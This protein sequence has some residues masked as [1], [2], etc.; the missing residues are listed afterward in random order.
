MSAHDAQ[1]PVSGDMQ[2]RLLALMQL[3]A[4]HGVV[5]LPRYCANAVYLD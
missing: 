1:L 5:L 3:T 4:T 2:A